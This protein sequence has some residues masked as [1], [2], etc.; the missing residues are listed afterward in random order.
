MT[1][2]QYYRRKNCR[3]CGSK[4]LQSAI[5]LKPTP[6]ANNY[7]KNKDEN[8]KNDLFPLEVFFCDDCKHLQLIDVVDPKILY[9]N[10]VYVSGTSPVFIEHFK[11]YATYLS[12]NYYIEGLAVDGSNDGTLLKNL[13]N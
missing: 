12:E 11:N 5:K 13:R 6:L 7:L 3:Q 10:Y 9:E 1:R 8:H 4:K 2:Q